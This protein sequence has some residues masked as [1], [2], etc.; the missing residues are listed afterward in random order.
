[1]LRLTAPWDDTIRLPRPRQ[2]FLLNVDGLVAQRRGVPRTV[3]GGAT[4][5]S[6]S[7][8]DHLENVGKYLSSAKTMGV[9][10]LKVGLAYARTLR[11]EAVERGLARRLHRSKRKNS[12]P[13]SSVSAC[14]A[15]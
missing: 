14:A 1:M 5:A 6:G 11:F 8:E 3:R 2:A 4:R 12:S 7:F 10:G 13:T 9:K 15:A